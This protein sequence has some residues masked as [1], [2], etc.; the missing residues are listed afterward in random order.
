MLFGGRSHEHQISCLSAAT[1]VAALNEAGH[2]VIPVGITREGRWTD[3]AVPN[4]PAGTLPEVTGGNTTALVTFPDGATLVTFD[5]DDTNIVNRQPIDVVFPVL[6][7][8]GG[9]DGTIQ[10]L[11]ETVGVA[12]VGADVAASTLGV[13]KVA[14]KHQFAQAGLPQVPFVAVTQQQFAKQRDTVLDTIVTTLN[15][16]WFVKPACEGSSFG[17]SRVVDSNELAD[18]VAGA[19]RFGPKVIVEEGKDGAR[20][21][22]VGVI[23]HDELNVTTPGEIVSAHTFYDF[24]AKYVTASTLV[25]PADIEPAI[26]AQIHTLAKQAYQAIGCRGLARVDFFL[27]DTQLLVNEINT[28]PGFTSQSM[29]PLLWAHEGRP[30][31]R[32]VDRLIADALGDGAKQA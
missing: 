12:Y 29:F 21:I 11:C 13:D 15:A 19:F 31:S 23:G 10:G 17:I 24:D 16:P 22:E 18:A 30:F 20:E 8:A 14:M 2:T 5:G 4:A 25:I 9:E 7:G 32:L 6:H 27:T 26:A 1:V 3:S 28:I